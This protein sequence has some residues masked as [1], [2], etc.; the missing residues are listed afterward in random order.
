MA[1][2]I[3]YRYPPERRGWTCY[4]CDETFTTWGSAEDHFGKTPDSK[5]GCLIK[6]QLG[7]ERGLLMELRK[8]EAE[9]EEWE[10]RALLAEQR[11][12]GLAGQVSEFERIAG[13]GVHELRCKLDSMQGL[14]VTAEALIYG[15]RER[16]PEIYAEVVG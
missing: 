6:I 16:S 1:E 3:G 5:P 11:E 8:R 9:L 12:E 7:N 13:G 14:V 2:E 4:H 10:Q 15:F